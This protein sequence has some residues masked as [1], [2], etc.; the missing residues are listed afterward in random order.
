MSSNQ[1]EQV[2]LETLQSGI[3]HENPVFVMLLGMCSV[4]AVTNTT[5]NALAM[6]LA[7]T[8]VLVTSMGLVSLMRKSI[9][10]EVR[11]A[12]YVIII[13]TF[14][15]VVDYS[16]QAISLELYNALGA[17]IALIVVNCIIL[18]RAE[19]HAAKQPV[20]VAMMNALGM[21]IGYTFALLCLGTVREVLGNGT[22]LGL[23]VLPAGFQPWVVMVLP[24]GG[25]FVLG[26]WLLLFSWLKQRNAHR[27]AK[28]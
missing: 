1:Q 23:H 16:I 3:W 2:T 19:A 25:F 15:T 5:L 7:V 10:K 4:L 21:G 22:I 27:I 24:P 12:T 6:G 8:F 13:A 17:F 28:P 26:S 9:P 14:V 18:A 11:I 20:G